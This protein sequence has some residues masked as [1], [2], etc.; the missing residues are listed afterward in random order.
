MSQII[1]D[2]LAKNWLLE[3]GEGDYT[4]GRRQTIL[5]LNPQAGYAVGLK[6][7]EDRVVA[8]VTDFEAHIV[9]YDQHPLGIDKDADTISLNL[10]SLVEKTLSKAGIARER[11]FGVGIGLAG[12]IY[13]GSGIVTT[14]LSLA[15]ATSPGAASSGVPGTGG[16]CRK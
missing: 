5:R 7:M 1:T 10:V 6:L 3:T 4:G 15:G 9:H 8:A 16:L 2:L 11:V 12:I 13:P 14:P